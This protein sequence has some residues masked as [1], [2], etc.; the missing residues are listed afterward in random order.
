MAA[1]RRCF[2]SLGAVNWAGKGHCDGKLLADGKER[3]DNQSKI[4]NAGVHL[5]SELAKVSESLILLCFFLCRRPHQFMRKKPQVGKVVCSEAKG[6]SLHVR[7][8]AEGER[9]PASPWNRISKLVVLL[10]TWD[11]EMLLRRAFGTASRASG[12]KENILSWQSS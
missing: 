7:K 2:H 4:K 1:G 10:E 8:S 12:Q 5:G 3:V 11:A 6:N 9:P